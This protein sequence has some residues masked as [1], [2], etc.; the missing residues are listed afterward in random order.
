MSNNNM[1]LSLIFIKCIM[2]YFNRA[3]K[4]NRIIKLHY[5]IRML[6]FVNE[7][8][9]VWLMDILKSIVDVIC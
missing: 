9:N 2:K 6:L 3:V 8:Y 7:N 5:S 4:Y 1:K